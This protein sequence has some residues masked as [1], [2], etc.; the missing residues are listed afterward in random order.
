MPA[1]KAFIV[2]RIGDFGFLLGIFFVFTYFGTL[3]YHELFKND[4]AVSTVLAMQG[5]KI[6][7]VFPVIAL[8]LF[9]GAT[10][11]SAQ[12]PLYIWLPDAMAGPTPVSALIHAATMV[13]A[14]V[15]MLARCNVFFLSRTGC[16]DGGLRSLVRRRHLSLPA[17][18]SHKRILKKC[19]PTRR[20]ASWVY[21]FL[22]CG[23]GAFS[24]AIFHV[25]THA[26]FKA[27]LFLCS[28][29][30][31]HAMHHEQDMTK[32]GGLKEKM[33]KTYWT[34][35]ISTLAIAGIFP[36]AGFWSKDEIL[37]KAITSNNGIG[38]ILWV[39]GLAAAIMTAFYMVR[40]VIL[41]FHGTPRMSEEKWDHVHESPSSMTIPLI[42]LAFGACVVGF[43]N[44]PAWFPGPHH[45]FSDF[46]A[47]ATEIGKSIGL[48]QGTFKDPKHY[49][50]AT[51]FG[52]AIL[53]IAIAGLGMFF[54]YY[55]YTMRYPKLPEKN[56]K[57]FAPLY[58]LS[59]NLWYYN[60]FCMKIVVGIFRI[61]CEIALRLDIR[62]VDSFREQHGC[63]CP[64]DR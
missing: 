21:M 38:P 14:G 32:M 59:Y 19:W 50:P 30:V 43:L 55:C 5:K 61:L 37:Y 29:S 54:A 45:V 13:T 60:M 23:V 47:P 62:L 56:A 57:A 63:V 24:V 36:F 31:I 17:L 4:G 64:W 7:W 20:S 49:L 41:T 51:E 48:D 9:V 35:V 58:S 40:S 39:V 12:I 22:A 27:C 8:L 11:K 46:L 18:V 16:N 3:D 6:M 53:S 33:P 2:N 26:F 15:Y 25:F 42:I 10:G 52:L 34:Y 44:L 28:G 1:K